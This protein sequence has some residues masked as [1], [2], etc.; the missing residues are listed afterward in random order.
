MFVLN[1]RFSINDLIEHLL[2]V[3]CNLF[4][5]WYCGFNAILNYNAF[6]LHTDLLGGIPDG[7]PNQNGN[8]VNVLDRQLKMETESVRLNQISFNILYYATHNTLLIGEHQLNKYN[9]YRNIY[10]T[11]LTCLLFYLLIIR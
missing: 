10:S 8:I 2:P 9:D 3:K 11:C 5:N 4:H 7:I 1:Y 6:V